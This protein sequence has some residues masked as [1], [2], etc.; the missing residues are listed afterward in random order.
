MSERLVQLLEL[1]DA[2]PLDSFLLFATGKEYEKMEDLEQ[3]LDYYELLEKTNPDYVGLY[4]HLGKL[5][6]RMERSADALAAYD[7]GMATAR[8]LQDQHSYNELS[9]ARL[10]LEFES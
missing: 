1:L 6:E 2:T 4:Y 8:K 9:G 10:N 3:A 7:R 5:L